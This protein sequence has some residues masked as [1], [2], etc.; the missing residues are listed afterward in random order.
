[1]NIVEMASR[2]NKTSNMIDGE[3]IF[4][5]GD[6]ARHICLVERGNVVILA[7]DGK[8]YLRKYN[9]GDL[10]GIPEVLANSAWP[11]MAIAAGNS[12]IRL[13]QADILHAKIDDMP[14]NHRQMI[15]YVAAQ[16]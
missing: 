5:A 2:H 7:P 10:F 1:M 8:T 12:R 16:A 3:I 13:F 9:A 4:R 15:H 14:E 11:V 6:P